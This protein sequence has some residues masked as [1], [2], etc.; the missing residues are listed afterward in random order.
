MH[1]ALPCWEAWEA[2]KIV[3]R[4]R[5]CFYDFRLDYDFSFENAFRHD[6]H[7]KTDLCWH[8]YDILDFQEPQAKT[9]STPKSTP[10]V[11]VR[12]YCRP[13]WLWT[14]S[15]KTWGGFTVQPQTIPANGMQTLS[16]WHKTSSTSLKLLEQDYNNTLHPLEMGH[17]YLLKLKDVF[18]KVNWEE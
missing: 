7:K 15:Q 18:I 2:D 1:C 16:T 17:A 13:H 5:E 14:I 10:W 6:K 4:C 11:Q 3:S 9:S 12:W 8:I